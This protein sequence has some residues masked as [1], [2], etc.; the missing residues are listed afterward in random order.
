VHKA[1][2]RKTDYKYTK[3]AWSGFENL[4]AFLMSSY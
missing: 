2:W 3:N 1:P 4:Q